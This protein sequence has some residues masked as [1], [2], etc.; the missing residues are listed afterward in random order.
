VRRAVEA[1]QH[2][3]VP[4]L[5]EEPLS[6]HTTIG[7]GGPAEILARPASVSDL[8][9]VLDVAKDNALPIRILGA[10][11][12]LLVSERGVRGIVIHTKALDNVRFDGREVTVGAGVHFPTL[13]RQT[14]A[15]GL[16]GLE[17]G[18]GIPGSVGGVLTMNAGAY[19][20][21][22]GRSLASVTAASPNKGLLELGRDEI[23]FRYR[24]SSFGPGLIVVAA[25][26]L[27]ELDDPDTIKREIEGFMKHRKET[28]PV[29]VKSAGC[30][31][32]N[33]QG[34]SAGR[35][36]DELGLKGFRIGGARISE[37]HANFIVHDG[38]ATAADVA[39][40]IDAVRARVREAVSVELE[41]EVMAWN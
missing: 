10:G 17:A 9:C 31:F 33:P 41:Q 23:D 21:S 38:T 18:V 29:G 34:D 32:K 20:F 22:I 39:A 27:L 5:R 26:L 37:V 14:A 25:K 24:S 6:K 19:D 2:A 35:L 7:V 36:L 13:V 3:G 12:N 4:F 11:S 28:Q 15:R 8:V 30:I 16:R 1:L 40:L